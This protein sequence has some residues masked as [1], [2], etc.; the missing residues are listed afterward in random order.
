MFLQR[1]ALPKNTLFAE[2]PDFGHFR[3]SAN[4]YQKFCPSL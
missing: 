4:F 1:L 3:R 2:K